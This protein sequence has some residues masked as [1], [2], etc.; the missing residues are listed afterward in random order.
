MERSTL[1]KEGIACAK[2]LWLECSGGSVMCK[3]MECCSSEVEGVGGGFN[4][5]S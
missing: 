3:E 1:E 4:C 5:I 2:A